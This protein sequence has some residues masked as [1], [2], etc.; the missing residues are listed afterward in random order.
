VDS[1][2]VDRWLWSVRLFKTRSAAAAACRAGHV[3][4]NGARVKPAAAVRVGDTVQARVADRMRVVE[5]ARIIHTRVGASVAADCLVDH[6]PAPPPRQPWSQVAQRD[7]QA[8]A[9]PARSV[10]RTA[11]RLTSAVPT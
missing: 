9:S 10:A 2:R 1:A 7:E 6:S 4:M 11:A 8:G 5:V 3:R